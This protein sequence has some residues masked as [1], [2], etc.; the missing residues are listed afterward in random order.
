MGWIVTFLIVR[1]ARTFFPLIASELIAHRALRCGPATHASQT[2]KRLVCAA[3]REDWRE[4]HGMIGRTL[5]LCP[6]TN[7]PQ[8][9]Q[10]LIRTG[11]CGRCCLSVSKRSGR[12]QGKQHQAGRTALHC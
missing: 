2:F 1:I 9:L 10:R 8:A 12:E 3:F 11:R 6:G 7:P 5:R 4:G